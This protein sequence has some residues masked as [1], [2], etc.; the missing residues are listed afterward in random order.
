MAK[1]YSRSLHWAWAGILLGLLN[2][3]LMNIWVTN[4]PI[5]ASTAFPYIGGILSGLKDSPY[6]Q[7]IANPGLWE[8]WFLLGALIGAF[9]SARISG[10]FKLQLIPERWKEAKG[11]SAAKRIFWVALGAFFLIFGARMA[12]GCTSGHILSGFMQF[13]AG[14]MAFGIV[15]MISFIITGKLFYRS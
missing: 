6:M 12:G 8:V 4:R 13:S 15:V 14:S 11:A 9:I 10:D 1:K 7:Q 5:G 3:V 2:V